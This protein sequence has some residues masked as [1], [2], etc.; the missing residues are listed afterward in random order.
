MASQLRES[1]SLARP[2]LK[3]KTLYEHCN[4]QHK[5]DSLSMNISERLA[6][7][8]IEYLPSVIYLITATLNSSLYHSPT[9]G[10]LLTHYI[11][12]ECLVS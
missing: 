8:T 12:K 11:V 10:L 7:L 6:A 3:L 9:L 1:A 2:I 4:K 5:S